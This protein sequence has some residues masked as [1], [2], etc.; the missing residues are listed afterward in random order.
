MILKPGAPSRD[1]V[2]SASVLRAPADP[3][4]GDAARAA[5]PARRAALFAEDGLWY[6]AVATAAGLGQQTA[7]DAL[8]NEVGL[9]PSQTLPHPGE[10]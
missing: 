6:D 4:L 5:S 2:A 9:I 3:R 7:L 1:I 8:M 10:G